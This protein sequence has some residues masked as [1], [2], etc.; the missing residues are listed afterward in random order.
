MK[1]LPMAIIAGAIVLSL[2]ACGMMERS[3]ADR[4]GRDAASSP[5]SSS[6]GAGSTRPSRDRSP[7][8]EPAPY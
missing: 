3:S 8:S 4:S 7:S 2:S 6:G 1:R 5:G